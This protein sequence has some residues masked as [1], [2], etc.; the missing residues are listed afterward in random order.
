MA[1][2]SNGWKRGRGKLGIFA[3]L[4][5]SWNAS[6]SSE[7]GP[8][9]CSRTFAPALGGAYLQLSARWQ[10][11]RKSY[12]EL[13]M[14][15]ADSDGRISFWS[16]TSD[17]KK[18]TGTFADATDVHPE[19]ISFEAQMPAG[20]ARMIY[21]PDEADGFY[22]AVESKNKKGWGRFVEHHYERA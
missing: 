14:I 11:G 10:F 19:A 18:S 15:G 22:W 1:K 3:P 7:L 4:I 6:G 2:A 20:L 13:A 5:G 16:F 8:F 9:T 17:G 12:E 21:W